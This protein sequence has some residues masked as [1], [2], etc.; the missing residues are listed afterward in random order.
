MD[1]DVT[2]KLRPQKAVEVV[3]TKAIPLE[4]EPEPLHELNTVRFAAVAANPAGPPPV[5]E[6]DPV[7][8]WLVVMRGMGFGRSLQLG[9]GIHSVGRAEDQR[10]SVR[11]GDKKISRRSHVEISYDNNGR[12][13]Y[14]GP[15]RGSTLGYLN[16]KPILQPSSLR[17]GDRITLGDTELAFVQFCGESFDWQQA[18]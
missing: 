12:A 13:F 11:F 1:I 18:K 6:P 14:I 4:H 8:G 5:A 7:T 15:G 16:G 3:P 9:Y 10:V 2:R 17:S